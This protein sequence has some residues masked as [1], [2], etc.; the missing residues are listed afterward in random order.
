M[1]D[2]MQKSTE[3]IAGREESFGM[4]MNSLHVSE[5]RMARVEGALPVLSTESVQES[6]ETS[7]PSARAS[8]GT[9]RAWRNGSPQR[10]WVPAR[11]AGYFERRLRWP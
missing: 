9:D 8:T 7:T 11:I 5:L 10:D 3:C 1:R 6:P 2:S 4:A